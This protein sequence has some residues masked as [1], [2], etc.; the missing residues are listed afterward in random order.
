MLFLHAFLQDLGCSEKQIAFMMK[1]IGETVDMG[2]AHDFNSNGCT[3]S[4]IATW[5]MKPTKHVVTI[6]HNWFFL[7]Q[8]IETYC[9][10]IIKMDLNWVS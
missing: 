9:H 2:T 7:D 6:D 5:D 3:F 8:Y 1:A 10:P 4:F